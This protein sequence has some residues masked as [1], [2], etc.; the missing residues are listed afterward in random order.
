MM[1]DDLLIQRYLD[2][3]LTNDE[4]AA[5]NQR[6]RED[7][8]LREHLRTVAEHAVAFGDMVRR[9]NAAPAPFHK[10]T[11]KSTGLASWLALAAC[12]ALLATSA[13]FFLHSAPSPVVTLIEHEGSVAWK[14]GDAIQSGESLPAGTLETIGEASSALLR[15]DDGSLISLRGEAELSFSDDGQKV[16]TLSRG[17]LSADVQKQPAGRPMLIRTPSAV[18]EVVGTAFDLTA[19]TEDTLLNVDE[20]IVKLKRLADGSQIDVSANRSA[21]ASLVAG[22]KLDAAS[23]PEPLTAWSFDF[24]ASTPPRDW[25]GI[26]K[27]GTMHASPYVAKKLPDGRIV[28]HHGISIRTAMLEQPLRLLVTESSVIRY[29]LRQQK[30]GDLLL[31]LLTNEVNGSHGGNF[32]CKLRAE[33]LTPGADGWCEV[34]IPISRYKPVDPRPHIRKRHPSATGNILTSAIINTYGED[35]HLEVSHFEL[36]PR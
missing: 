23:T 19:R 36:S 32:E 35:R 13:W 22:D 7:A 33:E 10:Q 8:A 31:M 15:F 1:N 28:T 26:A 6:L 4:L 2:N 14:N 18:A 3:K 16:L 9:E 24:T 20:G 17:T 25:R 12:A 5:L 30:P 27:N 29:R 11:E 34:A 21:V